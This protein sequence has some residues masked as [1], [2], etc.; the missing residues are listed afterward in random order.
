M[1]GKIIAIRPKVVSEKI[2][3]IATVRTEKSGIINAI[4][5][6]RELSALLPRSILVGE[7]K[8]THHEL[9][10]IISSMIKRMTLGRKVRLWNY[11]EKY[12]FSFLSWRKVIFT[13]S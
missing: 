11:Q 13:K 7:N 4:L 9:L 5:P 1:R 10:S 8:N 12:Y 6:D 3:I 2:K